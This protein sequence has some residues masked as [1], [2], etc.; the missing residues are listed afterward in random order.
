METLRRGCGTFSLAVE[1]SSGPD[2]RLCNH[3]Q[4]I[5]EACCQ[6]WPEQPCFARHNCLWISNWDVPSTQRLSGVKSRH[7][8][9]QCSRCWSCRDHVARA[10]VGWIR[11][12]GARSIHPA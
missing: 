5:V 3:L 9:E 10:G 12:C 6:D 11:E 8:C 1:T 2:P 7:C 4:P